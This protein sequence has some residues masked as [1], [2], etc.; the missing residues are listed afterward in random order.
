VGRFVRDGVRDDIDKAFLM[1][2]DG[3]RGRTYGELFRDL[4]ALIGEC[5]RNE[6]FFANTFLNGALFGPEGLPPAGPPVGLWHTGMGFGNGRRHADVI[7]VHSPDRAEL[8]EIKSELDSWRAAPPQLK[9]YWRAFDRVN[10]IL[11]E[12]FCGK[13]AGLL[14][15]ELGEPGDSIGIVGIR[16]GKGA[17]AVEARPSRSFGERLD[18]AVILRLLW[19]RERKSA[20]QRGVGKMPR[21]PRPAVRPTISLEPLS[22]VFY[23]ELYA[24]KTL[25]VGTAQRLAF[26]EL[27]GRFPALPPGFV[28]VP[29]EL[30]TAVYFARLNP[31][32]PELSRRLGCHFMQG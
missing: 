16:E 17:V 19:A 22:R 30:R 24:F 9:D 32:S 5:Y 3:P 13:M 11:P 2:L 26:A 4:Y 31:R 15:D 8:Y 27:A 25:G 1:H 18:H 7:L 28:E 14:R 12:R 6:Y 20:I 21:V 10:V 29:E 23:R